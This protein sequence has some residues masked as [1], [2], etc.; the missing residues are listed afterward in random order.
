MAKESNNNFCYEKENRSFSSQAG[1]RR[2][3]I[4]KRG[5]ATRA[6]PTRNNGN[7]IQLT[8]SLTRQLRGVQCTSTRQD[9]YSA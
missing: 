3:S 7:N 4:H 6:R 8:A 5:F 2:K 1:K 9:W